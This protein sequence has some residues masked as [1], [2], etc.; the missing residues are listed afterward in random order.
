MTVLS[1][2]FFIPTIISPGYS[3]GLQ[4]Y[5]HW[6]NRGAYIL[7]AQY[8]IGKHICNIWSPVCAFILMHLVY[9]YIFVCIVG[10][11][12]WTSSSRCSPYKASRKFKLKLNLMKVSMFHSLITSSGI[13][14]TVILYYVC[15]LWCHL[16]W[17]SVPGD[18]MT[19]KRGLHRGIMGLW[20]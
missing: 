18:V 9:F 2:F 16:C 17:S 6:S 8:Y 20:I 14:S 10:N 12:W 7:K 19:L 1:S 5:D 3:R 15:S 4:L 11:L 13:H